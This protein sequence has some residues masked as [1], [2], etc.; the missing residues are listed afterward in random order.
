M[1]SDRHD[2]FSP[3][4]T[5]AKDINALTDG[6]KI[7]KTRSNRCLFLFTMT[8][9]NKLYRILRHLRLKKIFCKVTNLHSPTSALKIQNLF[10]ES[11]TRPFIK[12]IFLFAEEVI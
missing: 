9:L 3:A 6:Q 10:S 12:E 1:Q 4:D 8:Y 5:E 2:Y 7:I 11:R